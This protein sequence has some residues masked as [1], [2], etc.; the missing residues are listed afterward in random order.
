VDSLTKHLQ[1]IKIIS[2]T[3]EVK[4]F[5]LQPLHG[6]KPA[7]K[8]G[9]FLTLIFHTRFGEKRRSYS[10]SSSPDLNE[11]LSITVKKVDNGEFSRW[12]LYEAKVNDVLQTSGASGFF[13]LPDNTNDFEQ[14]FFIAA[15][16]GITPC[17]SIIKT[18]LVTTDKQITLLYSNRTKKETIFSEQLHSFQIQYP[19]R[20]EV[21]FLNSNN[22]D[23]YS[24]RLSRWLLGFLLKEY[25]KVEKSKALFYLC[26]P[27]DY[28]Q[29][30]SITLLTESIEAVNIR[31]E[32]FVPL[33]KINKPKPP[34][35][36]A[37]LVTIHFN[38]QRYLLPV[39]YPKTILATAK[40]HHI[41][42]PYS[43]E[44][45][46]CGTCAATC[47]KGKIWMAYN[48]VLVET[49]IN[50]GRILTCQ[51]YPIEG[52]AEIIFKNQD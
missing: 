34:D 15:G 4:T 43:C 37:H 14:V 27:F 44:A 46:S 36:N 7:Y 29:M 12:F 17:Y 52:D 35:T 24:R 47:V 28:M 49:E 42:L 25:L 19:K 30:A 10:I 3:E 45:G 1:I 9:Q 11:P 50:K 13:C 20:F 39:Q 41:S 2:E 5:V 40:E 38:G 51:G 48:E 23:I 22:Y 33:P 21:I 31:K 6:W 16:S 32:V 8:A 18:L 26:G